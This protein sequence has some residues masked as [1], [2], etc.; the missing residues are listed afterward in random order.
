MSKIIEWIKE[1]FGSKEKK[2]VPVLEKTYREL[3]LEN[4]LE[5]KKILDKLPT[6]REWMKKQGKSQTE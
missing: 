3:A 2:V 6:H 5:T 1:I 4:Y